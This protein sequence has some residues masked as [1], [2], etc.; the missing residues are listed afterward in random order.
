MLVTPV[1]LA[2]ITLPALVAPN[3]A[4]ALIST[5]ALGV[6]L[7]NKGRV[8]RTRVHISVL[9]E[10][11]YLLSRLLTAIAVVA[12]ITALRHEQAA[13]TSFLATS[14]WVLALFVIGRFLTMNIVLAARRRRFGVHHTLVVGGGPL[15]AELAETLASQPRYGLSVCGYLEDAPD[16]HRVPGVLWLGGVEAFATVVPESGVDTVLVTGLLGEDEHLIDLVRRRPADAYDLLVVPRL[17]QFNSLDGFIDHIGAIP[18]MHINNPARR[19]L[20]RT[21]KRGLDIVVSTVSLVV[22]APLLLVC[23]AAVRIEGG[24][25]ILFRQERVGGDGRI[26]ECLKFRSMKPVDVRESATQWTIAGDPRVG[27]VGRV[28]RS[29]A[30]DELPQLWNILRGDMT[31]VGPRPERPHFVS[32]FSAEIPNYSYRHRVP[33]G[34]TGLAQVS[35]LRGDTPINDRARFD[36]YYIENWSLWMDIK[37]I[38]RTFSEVFSGK[39]R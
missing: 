8:Y 39:V 30:L 34:L 31:L 5:A 15:A 28:L 1:D 22:L 20:A 10:L 7:V 6:L 29:T 35:G 11:P 23:A 37:I 32:Q 3:H 4:K 21:V 24:P 2:T 36:N 18:V 33:S 19:G 17:H 9:D 12:V 14:V 16:A 13:V 38:L 26:F 27:R 25:G